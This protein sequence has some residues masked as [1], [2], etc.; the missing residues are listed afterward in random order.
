MFAV[1]SRPRDVLFTCI[2]GTCLFQSARDEIAS[3]VRTSASFRHRRV[4]YVR[5]VHQRVSTSPS[6]I[7]LMPVKVRS[8]DIG[9]VRQDFVEVLEAF[10][11]SLH[12]HRQG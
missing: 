11:K 9:T 4:L 6:L 3:T 1:Y 7:E 12:E 8:R 10:M 5:N 2:R